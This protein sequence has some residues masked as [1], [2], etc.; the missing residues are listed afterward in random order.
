MQCHPLLIVF[1]GTDAEST[2]EARF[3]RLLDLPPSAKL[4]YKVLETEGT[5]T[6]SRL[7]TETRL[8]PRTVRYAVTQLEAADLLEADV[9][10][11]DARKK[12]YRPKAIA[13]PD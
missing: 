12:V 3:E 1:V 8:A 9:Y 4:V 6:Q 11:P 13:R 5:L 7:A 10:F 2:P